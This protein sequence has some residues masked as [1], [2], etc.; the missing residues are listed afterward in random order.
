MTTTM[1]RMKS[2]ISTMEV[3]T[4]PPPQP[5]V[6]L[7]NAIK[8]DSSP[9]QV[10]SQGFEVGE[11]CSPKDVACLE[12]SNH[13]V[14]NNTTRRGVHIIQVDDDDVAVSNDDADMEPRMKETQTKSTTVVEIKGA[15]E[16]SPINASNHVASVSIIESVFESNREH[17]S[18]GVQHKIRGWTRYAGRKIR[19]WAANI[20]RTLT[21]CCIN[22]DT[23]ITKSS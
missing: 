22:V 12:N 16:E 20:C 2:S 19:G 21:P 4:A 15:E 9:E 23:Q 10:D 17:S 6:H 5:H 7:E 13:S 11:G 3:G 1:N 18:R 8:E 14:N